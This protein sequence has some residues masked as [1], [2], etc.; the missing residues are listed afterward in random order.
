MLQLEDFLRHSGFSSQSS[1]GDG[2]DQD[3]RLR[4]YVRKFL[5]LKMNKDLVKNVE[6][7]ESNKKTVSFAVQQRQKLLENKVSSWMYC[8]SIIYSHD[9]S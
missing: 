1:D 8:R 7:M 9:Y 2:E 6:M 5:H 4:S 3:V